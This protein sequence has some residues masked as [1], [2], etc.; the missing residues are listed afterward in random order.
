MKDDAPMWDVVI[1]DIPVLRK[2]LAETH[3]CMR[4]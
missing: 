2:R 4:P 3:D 1:N